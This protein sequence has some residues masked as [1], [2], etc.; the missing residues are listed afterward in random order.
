MREA[1]RLEGQSMPGM[2][3]VYET[4]VWSL[5]LLVYEAFSY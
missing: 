3:L 5:K 2:V 1:E 4:S